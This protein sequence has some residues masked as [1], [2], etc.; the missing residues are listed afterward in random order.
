MYNKKV[1]ED[2]GK[3]ELNTFDWQWDYLKWCQ[4]IP[5]PVKY[6]SDLV[7]EVGGGEVERLVKWSKN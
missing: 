4:S 3:L 2:E 1:N 7:L 5:K 6:K